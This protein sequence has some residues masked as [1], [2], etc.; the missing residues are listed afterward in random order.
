MDFSAKHYDIVK[1][2]QAGTLE[3]FTESELFKS[4]VRTAGRVI[5]CPGNPGVGKTVLSSFIIDYLLARQH[6]SPPHRP[7]GIAWVYFN[8]KESAAQTPD[9][10]YLSIIRQLAINSTE[11]YQFLES[12]PLRKSLS[13]RCPS[14]YQLIPDPQKLTKIFERV[15]IDVD[16]LDECSIEYWDTVLR[17]LSTL[18]AY[19]TNIFITSR[20]HVYGSIAHASLCNMDEVAIHG[21]NADIAN[22][23]NSQLARQRH[24]AVIIGKNP[25]LREDIV[26]SILDSCQGMYVLLISYLHKEISEFL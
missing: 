15:F 18:N 8:Y 11:L 12:S 9:A 14:P 10:I 2:R 23:I 26:N 1:S 16:A 21:R 17:I 25:A 19:G 24:L 6:F 22:Y 4:W 3:W 13:Q 20:H 5:W 7:I